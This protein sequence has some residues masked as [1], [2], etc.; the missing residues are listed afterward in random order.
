MTQYIIDIMLHRIAQCIAQLIFSIAL[1][2][3][4]FFSSS[5]YEFF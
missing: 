2:I 5:D 1:P 3:V 4:E